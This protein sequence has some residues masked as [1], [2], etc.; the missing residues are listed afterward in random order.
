MKT[1]APTPTPQQ[2]Y[3]HL[4]EV[5]F[6]TPKG[7]LTSALR[8]GSVDSR[9]LPK[10]G[11]ACPV[12]HL[13]VDYVERRVVRRKVNGLE[14]VHIY[15]YAGHIIKDANGNRHTKK[16]YLGAETY[17]YV[18]RK[19]PGINLKGMIYGLQRYTDY[20]KDTL[21]HLDTELASGNIEPEQAKSLLSALK[22][23][24]AR[25]QAVEDRLENYVRAEAEAEGEEQ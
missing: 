13:P 6:L 4:C 17:D 5:G 7:T 20:I 11:E 23:A 15:Y 1:E 9:E 10:R 24:V 12:C 8:W 14:R 2:F 16:C 25:L 22:E 19:N 21:T 3:P 18:A